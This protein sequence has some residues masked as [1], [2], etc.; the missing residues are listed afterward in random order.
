MKKILWLSCEFTE[1]SGICVKR[2]GTAQH[3]WHPS[4]PH[5]LFVEIWAECSH[6][7]VIDQYK[8]TKGV[9]MQTIVTFISSFHTG[10]LKFK[11]LDNKIAC[12]FSKLSNS[13]GKTYKFDQLGK[14][15]SAFYEVVRWHFFQ[16]W[17][18]C[19]QEP[20]SNVLWILC[21]KNY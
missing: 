3:A 7:T 4:H 14:K 13:G 11:F 16:I 5:Q 10:C 12:C 15:R 20:M 8:N 18:T 21:T 2:N 19:V 17:W 6:S 9:S 1:W